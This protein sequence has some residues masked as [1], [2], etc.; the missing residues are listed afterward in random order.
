MLRYLKIL[1]VILLLIA[2]FGDKPNSITEFKPQISQDR[3]EAR[4]GFVGKWHSRQPTKP[5]GMRL[6]VIE[7]RSDS[8]YVAEF[9][10]FDKYNNL[11]DYRKEF[12][13]W[14]VAG[15]IYFT[16]FKGWIE[17]DNL[18]EADPNNPYY[19]DAYQI[20]QI[21]K[22]TLVFESLSSGNVFKYTRLD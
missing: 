10:L 16:M 21:E 4:N 11:K 20:I 8:R 9:S 7:R 12:G 15:G 2:Y 3:K 6:T 17:D 5:G 13:N 22:D 14:G 19:Y 1:I 18:K